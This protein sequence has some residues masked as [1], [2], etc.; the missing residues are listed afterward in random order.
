MT[1]TLFGYLI[2]ISIDFYDLILYFFL[3]LVLIEKIYQTLKT[4]LEHISNHLEVCQK[5]SAAN[6]IFNSLLCVWSN[7]V[8]LGLSCLIYFFKE[9]EHD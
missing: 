6:R 1:M 5:Y 9:P 7:V 4:V 3:V 2:F 8:Y